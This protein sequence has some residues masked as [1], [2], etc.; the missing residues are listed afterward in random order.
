[1]RKLLIILA[2]CCLIGSAMAADTLINPNRI[3]LSKNW[4]GQLHNITNG[5]ALADGISLIQLTKKDQSRVLIY[6]DGANI[7]AVSSDGLVIDTDTYGDDNSALLQAACAF[8]QDGGN[9]TT[10]GRGLIAVRYM[11]VFRIDSTVYT[12]H[13]VMIDFGGSGVD[14]A[15]CNANAIQFGRPD[16]VYPWGVRT[17][18]YQK[19]TGV[20][21]AV[22]YGNHS[23]TNST[24]VAC[25]NIISTFQA[26]DISVNDMYN[27]FN[28]SGS[29]YSAIVDH[30]TGGPIAGTFVH[31]HAQDGALGADGPIASCVTNC[32]I[33]N[34]A[35][36]TDGTGIDIEAERVQVSNTYL[37][38]MDYGIIINDDHVQVNGGYIYALQHDIIIRGLGDYAHISNVAFDCSGMAGNAIQLDTLGQIVGVDIHDNDFEGAASKSIIQSDADSDLV[39]LNVHDNTALMDGTSI[40]LSL[41]DAMYY[42]TVSNNIVGDSDGNT[43]QFIVSTAGTA[44]SGNTINDNNIQKLATWIDAPNMIASMAEDNVVISVVDTTADVGAS[45][46]MTNNMIS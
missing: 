28:I 33:T 26:R 12:S 30:V 6:K 20:R 1:M 41:A 38:G 37:E 34:S 40:F 46:V 3:D 39:Y 36:Y 42:C 13:G 11:P 35:S 43:V 32:Q 17:D 23:L 5:T 27:C 15:N 24:F 31:F 18:G 21:N 7:I 8:I 9:A 19:I 22:V 10:Y 29:S 2:L 25:F 4:T 45:W 14:I 44:G 16:Y